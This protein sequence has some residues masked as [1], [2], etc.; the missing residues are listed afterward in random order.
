MATITLIRPQTG[1][2]SSAIISTGNYERFY[3]VGSVLAGAETVTVNT[4]LPDGVAAVATQDV[5]NSTGLTATNPTR[6]YFGGP[7]IQVSKSATAGACGVYLI[8]V[9]NGMGGLS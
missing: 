8:P 6:V 5:N 9:G 7:D 4:I 1:S 3:I 2:G